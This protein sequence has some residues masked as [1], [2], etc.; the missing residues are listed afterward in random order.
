MNFKYT[1]ISNNVYVVHVLH[2][3]HAVDM[4]IVLE[5]SGSPFLY[6]VQSITSSPLI[7]KN[8]NDDANDEDNG[9][10][11]PHHPDKALLLIDDWLG[12]DVGRHDW[13]RVGASCIHDLR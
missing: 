12:I 4:C 11:G 3:T 13:V 5:C 6:S 10:N 2:Y 1:Y 9:K 7:K 8:C